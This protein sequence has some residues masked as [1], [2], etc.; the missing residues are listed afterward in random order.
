MV[1]MDALEHDKTILSNTKNKMQK[2]RQPN[3][4]KKTQNSK[5]VRFNHLAV[6]VEGKQ[7]TI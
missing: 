2:L 4:E 1:L 6:E 7:Y 3:L 5:M